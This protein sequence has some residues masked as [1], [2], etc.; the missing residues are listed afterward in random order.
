ML[1]LFP[2]AGWLAVVTSLAA[3][4]VLSALGDVQRR[5]GIILFVWWLV[6]AYCQFFGSS[7][8]VAA[9]GLALQTV[10]AIYLVL[11]WRFTA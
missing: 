4:T 9:I 3:L 6:A 2:F 8:I 7:A 11:R 10:L 5:S 1:Q